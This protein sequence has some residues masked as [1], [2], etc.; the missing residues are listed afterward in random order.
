MT[1]LLQFL[2]LAAALAAFILAL[3]F[4]WI[5][6]VQKLVISRVHHVV[7]L[8]IQSIGICRF[9]T[10]R[11]VHGLLI[12]LAGHFGEHFLL[13]RTHCVLLRM[14]EIT[15]FRQTTNQLVEP[16]L[17]KLVVAV[18]TTLGNN[19]CFALFL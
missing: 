4:F 9:V 18:N 16:F 6:E 13:T 11:H 7:L 14:L 1:F 2:R 10:S 17:A 5:H 8:L 19:A 15:L 12:A 3:V